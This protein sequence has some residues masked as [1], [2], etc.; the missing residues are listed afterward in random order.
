M[1][2]Q[3][4]GQTAKANGWFIR[5]LGQSLVLSELQTDTETIHSRQRLLALITGG[6]WLLIGIILLWVLK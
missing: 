1:L 2:R 5:G 6:F 3:R 4:L